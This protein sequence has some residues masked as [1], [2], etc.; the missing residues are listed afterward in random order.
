MTGRS[1][2]HQQLAAAIAVDWI[3]RRQAQDSAVGERDRFVDDVSIAAHRDPIASRK[4]HAS[5]NWQ[6]S[7]RSAIGRLGRFYGGLRLQDRNSCTE[8]SVWI[9]KKFHNERVLL[10]HLLND[11]SLNAA[12]AAVDEPHFAQDLPTG[13]R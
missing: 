3:D 2:G 5:L 10:E 13:L 6:S 4:L 1:N 12:A 7:C 11:P 9:V 8:V